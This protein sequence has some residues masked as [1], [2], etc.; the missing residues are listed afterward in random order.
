MYTITGYAISPASGNITVALTYLLN[1]PL[2]GTFH[3]F[4]SV[5]LQDGVGALSSPHWGDADLIAATAAKIECDASEVS[6]AA[7]PVTE[8]SPEPEA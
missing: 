1:D 7:A 4:G 8:P 5:V 6:I 2:E 3:R